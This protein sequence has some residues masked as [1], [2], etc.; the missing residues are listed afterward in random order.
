MASVTKKNR[1]WM[2][3]LRKLIKR[4][5]LQ[6]CCHMYCSSHVL[7]K[8]VQLI[9]RCTQLADCMT[10]L[11]GYDS[12]RAFENAGETGSS[13]LLQLNETIMKRLAT[14]DSSRQRET[15]RIIHFI[16]SLICRIDPEMS[17]DA[18]NLWNT[19]DRISLSVLGMLSSI[20]WL[21]I[22]VT[23]VYNAI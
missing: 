11:Q 5:F 6:L 18:L 7:S 20:Q 15:T 23:E 14:G 16:G 22:S 9:I 8:A 21:L 3:T 17:P 4:N 1:F 2:T 19:I 12:G 13:A 10:Q